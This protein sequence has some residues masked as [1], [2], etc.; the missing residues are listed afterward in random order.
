MTVY[1]LLVL[2][3]IALVLDYVGANPVLVFL[4]SALA[5]VPLARLIGEATEQLSQHLGHTWGGLL[6]ATMGN[7]PEM[8]IRTKEK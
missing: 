4:T 5:I 2:L 3:P 1:Y 7:L 8:V 6:N